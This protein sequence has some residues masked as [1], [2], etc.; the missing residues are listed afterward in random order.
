MRMLLI[1]KGERARPVCGM[2]R[3][4]GTPGARATADWLCPACRAVSRSSSRIG[5]RARLGLKERDR[6]DSDRIA[7]LREIAEAKR[8]AERRYVR[9]GSSR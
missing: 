3:G 4:L 7:F 9:T 2:C 1:R 6:L 5:A 8:E